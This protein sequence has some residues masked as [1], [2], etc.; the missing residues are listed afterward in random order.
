VLERLGDE[1][2]AAVLVALERLVAVLVAAERAKCEL[3]RKESTSAA[4]SL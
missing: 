1:C 3:E 2:L 4:R